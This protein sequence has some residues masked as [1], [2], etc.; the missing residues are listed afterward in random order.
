MKTRTRTVMK[1]ESRFNGTGQQ[2]VINIIVADTQTAEG[3]EHV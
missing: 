3:K 2:D 1:M